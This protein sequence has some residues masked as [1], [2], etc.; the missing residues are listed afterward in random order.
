MPITWNMVHYDVQLIGGIV[1]HQGKISEKIVHTFFKIY[2]NRKY[3]N[4]GMFLFLIEFRNVS[5]IYKRINFIL[6]NVYHE[7]LGNCNFNLNER[8]FIKCPSPSICFGCQCKK[9]SFIT[10]EAQYS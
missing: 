7:I 2:Y 1:L 4:K 5:N 10:K 6:Y 3:K 9:G 8:S